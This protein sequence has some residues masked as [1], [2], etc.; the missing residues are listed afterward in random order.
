MVTPVNFGGNPTSVPVKAGQDFLFLAL[1]DTCILC[2]E[3]EHA[4]AV[5]N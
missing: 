5:H 1:A 4:G 2:I 3:T